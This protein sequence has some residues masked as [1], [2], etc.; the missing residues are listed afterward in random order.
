MWGPLKKFC[1]K[2]DSVCAGRQRSNSLFTASS[3]F[4]FQS[5]ILL[6]LLGPQIPSRRQSQ[7]CRYTF[8]NVWTFSLSHLNISTFPFSSFLVPAGI[9]GA[10][11]AVLQLDCPAVIWAEPC[12]A[13]KCS[14]AW[15]CCSSR[16]VKTCTATFGNCPA[17]NQRWLFLPPL[18]VE[19]N[20]RGDATLFGCLLSGYV[21]SKHLYQ[22]FL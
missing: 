7:A 16:I 13:I 14:H 3:C 11:T 6:L 9:C 10:N 4:V 22:L 2:R 5:F 20:Q 21:L 8:R 17:A 1:E 18:T 19:I 15:M 12:W